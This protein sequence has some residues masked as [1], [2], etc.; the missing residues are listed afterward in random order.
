ME[1][2]VNKWNFLFRFKFL[3]KFKK[4][5]NSN[6]KGFTLLEFSYF[7]FFLIS[8]LLT[9]LKIN[10]GLTGVQ[11]ENLKDFRKSWNKMDN[12]YGKN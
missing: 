4:S 12:K 3:R 6:Q 7:S 8:I 5:G 10:K 2:S 1:I 9:T 11:Q